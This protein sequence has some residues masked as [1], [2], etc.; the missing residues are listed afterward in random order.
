VVRIPALNP[1]EKRGVPYPL[2]AP[3]ML[4]TSL[5]HTIRRADVVH[6]HDAIYV[7]CFTAAIIAKILR[8]PLV[9]TQHVG[10]IPHSRLVTAV[11]KIMHKT[12]GAIVYRTSKVVCTL[13]DRVEQHVKAHGVKPERLVHMANG[14]DTELFHPA[15]QYEKMAAREQLGLSHD[16]TIVLFV[17]RAVPKK[18]YDKVLASASPNYQLVFA[19]GEAQIGDEPHI[20]YL[21]KLPQQKLALVYRAA[22]MFVLPSEGEGFPMSV[23]EAMASGLPII[24]TDDEG[25][26][27]YK[28][29]GDFVR[30]LKE[31]TASSVAA[32]IAELA[33]NEHRRVAMGKYVRHYAE[34]HFGWD[35]IVEE[36]ESM[37][38]DLTLADK[39]TA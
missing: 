11:Q 16:K 2:T 22:D 26:A 23:Q 35:T 36:L 34:T 27:R 9:L 15:N 4:I 24:T 1:F 32:A 21:G 5:L 28:L 7:P 37:Y 20:V 14:V 10:M 8:K 31:P 18:G 33:A 38:S 39:A 25:Y 17:G 30:L 6:V 29:D 13:N 3:I 19:G 12:A